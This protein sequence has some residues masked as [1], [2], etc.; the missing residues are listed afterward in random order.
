[1]KNFILTCLIASSIIACSPTTNKTS[2]AEYPSNASGYNLDSS[3]NIDLVKKMHKTFENMDSVN[4]RSCYSDSAKFHDNDN[5]QTLSENLANFNLY[6]TKGITV[7][8]EKLDP[9]W[10]IVNKKASADGITNYVESY[11]RL[12]F[13]RGDKKATIIMNI[14]NSVKDGKIIE[15][16]DTYDT[17]QM[18][19]ILK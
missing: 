16:W 8:I 13:A 18:M 17:K 4:Y 14:V 1:M 3:S 19:E 2:S 5:K 9:I 15:E 11:V 7:K 12:T 10:E 6:K